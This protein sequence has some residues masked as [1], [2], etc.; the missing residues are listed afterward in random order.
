[1][2]MVR[3]AA[4]LGLLAIAGCVTAPGLSP[5]SKYVAMGSSFAAGPGIPTYV[6][7]P[8]QPCTRSSGNYAHQLAKRKNL[9]LVDVSCSGG[10][11]AHLLG[12][13]NDIPPQLDAVDADTKLVTVTIGGN[14]VNY[15][16]RLTTAS[17]AAVAQQTGDN[18]CSPVPSPP[19]EEMYAGLAER[20]DRIAKEVRRRA[21]EARLVFVDYL[22]VLPEAGTCAATPLSPAEADID[23]E[24]HRRVAAIT[25]KAAGDNKADVVT[26]SEFSKGHDACAKEPFMN[27]YPRPGAPVAGTAYHPNLAGMTAIADALEQLLR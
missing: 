3:F 19:T 14:D 9:K 4:A 11:T 24:I 27:G 1:M 16:S 22:A 20:M 15:M 23:R 2:S 25:R 10:V 21:P 7:D 8:P 26:A 5:G 12:P 6:D 17:C 13:R 18:K